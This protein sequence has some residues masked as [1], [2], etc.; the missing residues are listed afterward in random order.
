MIARF[1]KSAQLSR[2]LRLMLTGD[3][4]EFLE[5]LEMVQETGLDVDSLKSMPAPEFDR[6]VVAAIKR[7]ASN[8]IESPY[9]PDECLARLM[10]VLDESIAVLR[11]ES[12]VLDAYPLIRQL[13]PLFAVVLGPTQ[14]PRCMIRLAGQNM[15]FATSHPTLDDFKSG[16]FDILGGLTPTH[17]LE[18]REHYLRILTAWKRELWRRVELDATK[19]D[20]YEIAAGETTAESASIA[21]R[22]P[23]PKFDATATDWILGAELA[24]FIGLSASRMSE[25]RKQSEVDESDE[26]GRWGIDGI[27]T[28][29]R[30]V[31]GKKAVAYY[32]PQIKPTYLSKY[33]HNKNRVVG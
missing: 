17:E 10:P 12:S 29:R 27:G 31:D 11:A 7:R 18:L 19:A 23:P 26:F 3:D 16:S 6:F 2:S 28:F 25:Y 8:R 33:T 21:K 24:R 13:D 14:F 4:D 32:V 20:N 9:S 30:A 5:L 1:R 22:I 15:E